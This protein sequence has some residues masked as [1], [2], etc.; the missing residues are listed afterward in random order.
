[1]EN[2]VTVLGL[3]QNHGLHCSSMSIESTDCRSEWHF[4][5][6][7]EVSALVLTNLA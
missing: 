5:V 3:S 2:L 1:M 4:I 6:H 7:S